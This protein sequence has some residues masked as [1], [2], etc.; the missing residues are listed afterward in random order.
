M[1]PREQ[2]QT[3]VTP[4]TFC[5]FIWK[6]DFICTKYRFSCGSSLHFHSDLRNRWLLEDK[7]DIQALQGFWVPFRFFPMHRS[8]VPHPFKRVCSQL[9]VE[10]MADVAMT[11][12][13]THVGR[14]T[15]SSGAYPK[16]ADKP[17]VRYF[18]Q[19][20]CLSLFITEEYAKFISIFWCMQN[21]FGGNIWGGQH[22]TTFPRAK[23]LVA[24]A[25][26]GSNLVWRATGRVLAGRF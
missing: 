20:W 15:A 14:S 2:S 16:Q 1:L 26:M 24:D 8:Y 23:C 18:F 7:S 19:Y 17:D 13:R 10:P 25:K 4:P 12:L 3:P 6:D 5:T 21:W 9:C 22:E 11:W